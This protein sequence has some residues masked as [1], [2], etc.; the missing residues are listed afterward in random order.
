MATTYVLVPQPFWIFN[1]AVGRPAAN[2]K[3][4]FYYSDTRL[5]R[6]VFKDSSGLFPWDTADG[7]ILDGA[8][9]V[10]GVL[11]FE[12]DELTRYF[13]EVYDAA[14]DLIDTVDELPASGSGG[15]GPITNYFITDNYIDNVDFKFNS[16]T[17]SPIP[18][19]DTEIAAGKWFF[20]K[21]ENFATDNITFNRIPLG[22]INPNF[23]PEFEFVYTATAFSGSETDKDLYVSEPN[24][25]TFSNEEIT[26]DFWCNSSVA[27][28]AQIY[29]RQHFGTG[30]SPS[31]DVIQLTPF[32]LPVGYARV[33]ITLN[34]PSVVSKSLGTNGDD[35][36][37]IGIRLPLSTPIVFKATEFRIVRGNIVPVNGTFD[38][39]SQTK[40][41]TFYE[42][43]SSFFMIGDI[44][45]TFI[46]QGETGRA[47]F[48]RLFDTDIGSSASGSF[49]AD[50]KY[51]NL[52]VLLWNSVG[53]ENCPVS[54]GR[55]P[56]GEADFVANKT[57][58]LPLNE[59][60]VI[61]NTSSI[62]GVG[63]AIGEEQHT[64]TISE[65]PAHTH[66][67]RQISGPSIGGG[68]AIFSP[69]GSYTGGTTDFTGGSNPHNNIQP[70]V[71]SFKYMKY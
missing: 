44:I 52:F 7:L 20:R 12:N 23:N 36:F 51:L 43:P 45:S 21:A 39:Y 18:V 55:G 24:V 33:T 10:P 8:G 41:K 56:S 57:M 38:T 40:Y 25:K 19:G 46:Y 69:I 42:D 35:A 2:G 32:V 64:L 47:G 60:R 65:I 28:N 63:L 4:F 27:A 58:Q 31:L 16:G 66:A 6:A 1:D 67:I 48:I 22:S 13:V 37:D 49:Y 53:D 62:E 34:V 54:G 68:P 15:S 3:I 26:I 14:G 30:G 50:D 5:P 29:I 11:Y 17:I 70:T 59:G 71:Y 9:M 61:G